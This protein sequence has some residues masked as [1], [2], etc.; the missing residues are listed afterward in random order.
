M[1]VPEFLNDVL[2]KIVFGNP[3]NAEIL[4]DLI[5]SV[6][7]FE[8]DRQILSLEI[9][10]P[11]LEKENLLDKG[12]VLDL[13]CRDGLGRSFNVEV[14]VQSQEQ[15]HRRS[16]YYVAKAYVEQLKAGEP[17]SNLEGVY[18]LTSVIF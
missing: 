6:L 12:C 17:Y 10:S 7:E 9:L 4:R 5:N 16:F 18:S 13:F 14:Q 15:Y 8:G 3:D 11:V 2:F 1:L